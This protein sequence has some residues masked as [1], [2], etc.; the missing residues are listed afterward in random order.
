M[1]PKEPER[2]YSGQFNFRLKEQLK[3][4]F[5]ELCRVNRITMSEALTVYMQACLDANAVLGI[6]LPAPLP[7]SQQDKRLAEL[8]AKIVEFA[9]RFEALENAIAKPTQEDNQPGKY[10]VK[11]A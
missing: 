3:I 6:D 5:T 8:E 9:A 2:N 11:A 4:D 10:R 7:N 1:L